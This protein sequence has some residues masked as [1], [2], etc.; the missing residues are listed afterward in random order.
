MIQVQMY[1]IQQS[2]VGTNL[3]NIK[4]NINLFGYQKSKLLF[5]VTAGKSHLAKAESRDKM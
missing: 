5:E 4:G 1:K 2:L 3:V